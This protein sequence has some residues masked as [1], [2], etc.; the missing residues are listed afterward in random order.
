MLGGIQLQL[1]RQKLDHGRG[2]A[3]V[4]LQPHGVAK[5]ALP[6]GFFDGL[7]QIVGFQFLDGDFGVARDVEDVRLHDLQ[8][9]KQMLQIGD[10]QLLQPNESVFARRWHSARAAARPGATAAT[11]REP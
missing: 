9:R 5:T 8:A 4:H 1:A 6:H 2:H 10:D 7:Q 11:C 3:R